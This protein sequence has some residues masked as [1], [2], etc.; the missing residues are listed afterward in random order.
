MQWLAAISVKRPVFATV[1][2][3]VLSVIGLFAYIQLG[4]D[5]FPKVDFPVVSVVTVLPGSAPDEVESEISDKVEAAVNTISGMDELRSISAEGVSQVLVTF[6]LEKDVEVAAQEVRD[7]VSAIQ[8][9]LPP[10]VQPPVITKMDPDA[11][12]ILTLA[13]SG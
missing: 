6:V 2:I 12:P 7:K 5:R 4:V 9:E 13:L 3:L 8:A 10:G 11:S 1:I